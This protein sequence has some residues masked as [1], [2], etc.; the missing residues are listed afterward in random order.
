MR[1][2]NRIRWHVTC[3]SKCENV[4][5]DS[6]RR[7]IWWPGKFLGNQLSISRSHIG[8]LLR[9]FACEWSLFYCLL[10]FLSE[11]QLAVNDIFNGND[12]ILT[13]AFIPVRLPLARSVWRQRTSRQYLGTAMKFTEHVT[14][15]S[16]LMLTGPDGNLALVCGSRLL[17]CN[18][19]DRGSFLTSEK[20]LCCIS[21]CASTSLI[22][23][24]NE[25][26]SPIR[27]QWSWTF[28]GTSSNENRILWCSW[29]KNILTHQ[30]DKSVFLDQIQWWNK[31]HPTD[32]R[33]AENDLHFARNN[34]NR[35][36]FVM[37]TTST[38]VRWCRCLLSSR[39]TCLKRH[40]GFLLHQCSHCL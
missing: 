37:A 28:P 16:C 5:V 35:H 36:S 38:S 30:V 12:E 17:R 9:S 26:E 33:D 29:S 13:L 3:W 10:V 25:R 2:S 24:L 22:W 27:I 18:L 20:N 15:E 40:R 21:N 39:L 34:G 1:F 23:D 6:S 8:L 32:Q 4:F 11:A 31:K 14:A 19:S 7:K